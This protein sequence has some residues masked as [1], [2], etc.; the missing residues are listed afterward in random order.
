MRSH[1]V[2]AISFIRSP[3]DLWPHGIL[4]WVNFDFDACLRFTDVP[5]RR[6]PNGLLTLQFAPSDELG[7]FDYATVEP[8]DDATRIAIE[9]Q[10]FDALAKDRRLT[11]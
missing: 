11:S 7:G 3:R 4:G 10:V 9:T 5:V 1:E 2:T 8:L 6:V